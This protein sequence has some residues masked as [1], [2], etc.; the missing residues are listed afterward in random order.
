MQVALRVGDGHISRFQRMLE[1]MMAAARAYEAP[2]V[3]FQFANEITRIPGP[4]I[5]SWPPVPGRLSSGVVAEQAFKHRARNA[6]ILS[7]VRG[8]F[9][10]PC[11]SAFGAGAMG[12][13]KARRSARPCVLQGVECE[14]GLRA[15]PRRPKNRDGGA[16]SFLSCPFEVVDVVARMERSAMR[17]RPVPDFASLHPGYGDQIKSNSAASAPA[18]SPSRSPRRNPH[19]HGASRRSPDRSR[20]RARRVCP[21]PASRRTR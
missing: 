1:M 15:R 21:P 9:A 20:A 12:W 8:D 14:L 16:L 11:A 17:D 18:S 7:A 10:L 19:R 2:A 5:P 4:R 13:L 3:R 6:G